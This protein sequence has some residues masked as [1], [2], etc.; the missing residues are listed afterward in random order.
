MSRPKKS[1]ITRN[2]STEPSR[3]FWASVRESAAASRARPEWAHG[4]IDLN[5]KNFVTGTYEGLGW[6]SP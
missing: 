6:E 3:A 2:E 5:P 1:T 4:G